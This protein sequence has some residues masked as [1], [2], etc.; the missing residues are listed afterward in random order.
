V[1][2]YHIPAGQRFLPFCICGLH[3]LDCFSGPLGRL[4]KLSYQAE[5]RLL[6]QREADAVSHL[7]RSTP[8]AVSHLARSTPPARALGRAGPERARAV[9][10]CKEVLSGGAPAV[11]GPSPLARRRE[12]TA[13]RR[14][15]APVSQI[16]TGYL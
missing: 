9:P 12:E 1:T 3:D 13:L 8:P 5:P 4:Q 14:N 2:L 6:A 11:S 10:C 16:V 7:A 15:G